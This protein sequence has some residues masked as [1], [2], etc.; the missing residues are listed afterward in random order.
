M[1]ENVLL[2]Q[3]PGQL[4]KLSPWRLQDLSRDGFSQAPV[5]G[6]KTWPFLVSVCAL[7]SSSYKSLSHTVLR[8]T[9]MTSS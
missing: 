4:N 6:R 3:H 9:P 8:S 7:L 1:F 5:L 2:L